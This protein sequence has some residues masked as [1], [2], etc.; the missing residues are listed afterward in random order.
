MILIILSCSQD[1]SV[2]GKLPVDL[3]L[4]E[5]CKAVSFKDFG[6]ES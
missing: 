3:S 1:L 2:K 6:S 5:V 4:L